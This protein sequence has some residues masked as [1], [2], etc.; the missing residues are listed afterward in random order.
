MIRPRVILFEAVSTEPQAEAEEESLPE[1]D[2]RLHEIA[3]KRGW[4]IIDV[5]LVDGF[6]RVYYNYRDFAE[7]AFKKGVKAPMRMFDHWERQDFDIFAVSSGDRFGREQSIFAEVV[8][9]TIDAGA[10][11]FTLRDGDIHKGNR[12]MFVSMA[13]YS[14][15]VEIDELVRRHKM[16]MRK[17]AKKGL[18]TTSYGLI[19][20]HKVVEVGKGEYKTVVNESA[21]RLFLDTAEL[22]LAGLSWNRIVLELA[23]RGHRRPSGRPYS[24]STLR[25]WLMHPTLHGN[26]AQ[27]FQDGDNFSVARGFWVFDP[28]DPAPEHVEIFYGTHEPMYTGALAERVKAELRRRYGL[29]GKAHPQYTGM[30]TGL[31]VCDMCHYAASYKR[32]KNY[33]A[34]RCVSARI[35]DIR[36]GCTNTR[37][38]N[39]KKL[40]QYADELLRE[41]VARADLSLLYNVDAE[42]NAAQERFD[43][44]D[45]DIK[46][47][48][49]SIV[50]LQGKQ[51]N[52]PKILA[53]GYDDQLRI[54]AE[55]VEAMLLEQQ[56]IAQATLDNAPTHDQLQ[57]IEEVTP[58]VLAGCF[59]TL[60][61]R[62]INQWLHRILRNKRIVIQ[63]GDA[64]G[65]TSQGKKYHLASRG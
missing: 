56:R 2:R 17:L 3:S 44:L 62:E 39:E 58:L 33:V 40:I 61:D 50:Y 35:P 21:R 18:P 55:A 7:A 27:H 5:I 64:A 25:K 20:S 6:S 43:V 14:A 26:S 48:Y 34:M 57:A 10:T 38:V 46:E 15:A 16:G 54:K 49:A 31:V 59:W 52:M 63:D 9:R 42:T 41:C 4:D 53:D 11:V 29:N 36:S 23:G 32:E 1:Q 60:A 28:A 12:R 22:L 19:L 45:A 51:A 65:L 47:A 13:G 37:Y 8:A 30:F 24:A